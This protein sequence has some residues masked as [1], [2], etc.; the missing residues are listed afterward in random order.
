[1]SYKVGV[2]N[3]KIIKMCFDNAYYNRFYFVTC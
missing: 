3:D 2:V 1:M